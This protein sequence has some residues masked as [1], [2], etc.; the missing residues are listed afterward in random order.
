[1]DTPSSTTLN[2]I[3]LAAEAD[4][5]VKVG[6]LGDVAGSLPQAILRA[7]KDE[8]SPLDV[9]IRM[10]IPYHN[11]IKEKHFNVRSLGEF[12]VK[13]GSKQETCQVFQYDGCS[14]PVYLLDGDP[15]SQSANVYDQDQTRDGEKYVFFSLA[16][17][18]LADFLNWPI[19]ILHAND[20]HTAIAIYALHR[21]PKRPPLL[22]STRTL[23][24]LHN[25]PFMGMGAQTALSSYNL[26]PAKDS[27]LPEWARHAPLPLGLL[28]ADRIIA[29]SPHYAEEILTPEY[30]CGLD[31]F[32]K[33]RQKDL[34]GIL[35]GLNTERWNPTSDTSIVENFS[36]EALN[37]RQLNKTHLQRQFGLE[38]VDDRPLLTLISRMDPQK[39]IDI[40]LRGLEKFKQQ[41]WQAIILGTGDPEIE[42]LARRLEVEQPERVRTIIGFDSDLAHQLYAGADIFMMP[43]RYEP[44][45]LSQMI[46]MRYGCV[47]VAR[48]T[49]GL[50]DTIQHISYGINSG[51]GFLFQ[52]P[53]PSAFINALSR[54]LRYYQQPANWRHI[55]R[56]GML[57]DFSWSRSARQ[58]LGVYQD[59]AS[60]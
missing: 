42:A 18:G 30:G 10:V 7:A 5:F 27:A 14:M 6:G 4:P 2:V 22:K 48:A 43:S 40:T 21:L 24:T 47:P 23:L 34:S 16:A 20:W 15:I 60:Q 59:I 17:L 11:A 55:Q 44:C 19:H 50:A 8:S 41:A 13:R 57:T 58:Y 52:Q 38:E 28:Y 26:P 54:A 31:D 56:N 9:D 39:G 3:F 12:K 46:A 37:N 29:V 51:T 49:G 32:L 45:G 25:L 35:N 33:T 53:Y 1:M 36:A